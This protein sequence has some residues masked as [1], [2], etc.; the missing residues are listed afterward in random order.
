MG[1]IDEMKDRRSSNSPAIS[2]S[3]PPALTHLPPLEV[4]HAAG[5]IA[6]NRTR[7]CRCLSKPGAVPGFLPPSARPSRRLYLAAM[8]P[9]DKANKVV[10]VFIP[11]VQRRP[12]R[13]E[14]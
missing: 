2:R 1:S 3:R 11:V 7:G 13:V 12:L 9:P 8:Q 10:Q 4:S 14:A 6:G 5:T